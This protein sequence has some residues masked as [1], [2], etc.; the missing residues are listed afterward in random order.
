M[1]KRTA[2]R[3]EQRNW[4]RDARFSVFGRPEVEM[5]LNE[6]AEVMVLSLT[7]GSAISRHWGLY[8]GGAIELNRNVNPTREGQLLLERI[9]ISLKWGLDKAFAKF[10]MARIG[11]PGFGTH[12]WVDPAR[13]RGT[14]EG[15][16]KDEVI[17]DGAFVLVGAE[18]VEEFEGIA[19]DF[20]RRAMSAD[21]ANAQLKA[22][23][24]D[25][26][27]QVKAE[28]EAKMEAENEV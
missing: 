15:A 22:Q 9:D 6:V 18:G 23:I 16:I 19:A 11:G 7:D 10:P 25:R 5:S 14:C 13:V 26:L 24:N 27:D 4:V 3:R 1:S 12:V 8:I 2:R 28:V 20:I 17:L 21:E